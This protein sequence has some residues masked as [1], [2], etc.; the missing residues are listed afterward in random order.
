M[1]RTISRAFSIA[2]IFYYI[3]ILLTTGRPLGI[4]LLWL[5]FAAIPPLFVRLRCRPALRRLCIVLLA[6]GLLCAA[7]AEAAI[8]SAIIRRPD[9]QAAYVIVLGAKVNG[10]TPS[11][12]LRYRIE[13]AADYLREHPDCK[14]IASGGQGP[15]EGISE[16]QAI[17]DTLQAAG[18]SADRIL[19]ED[20]SEST[21]ENLGFSLALM[22]SDGGSTDSPVVIVTSDFHMFRALRLAARAGYQN[23]SGKTASSMIS[24]IPQN[25]LREI[26][27]VGFYFLTGRL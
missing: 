22:E 23:V 5:L 9:P 26:L 18:I 25:H 11:R 15:D 4:Q 7:V 19:L 6:F 3:V 20:R 14:A 12:S 24:L 16:A 10:S 8:L 27:A 17:A 21:E 13:S 2:C 1:K